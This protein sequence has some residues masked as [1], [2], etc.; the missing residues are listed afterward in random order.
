M[1]MLEPE[2]KGSGGGSVGEAGCVCVSGGGLFVPG[3][4]ST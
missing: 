1:L 4:G 2:R 3:G